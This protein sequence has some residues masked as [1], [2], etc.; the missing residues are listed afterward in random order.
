MSKRSKYTLIGAV[1]T[2]V[3]LGLIALVVNLTTYKPALAALPQSTTATSSPTASKV[4]LDG[5]WVAEDEKFTATI[6]NNKITILWKL[7]ETSKGLYWAGDFPS[8]IDEGAAIISTANRAKLDKS[9]VASQDDTKVF[10]HEDDHLSF[11]FGAM[12]V[13][14]TVVLSKK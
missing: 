13:T 14:K 10:T 12:G 6:K 8:T 2:V 4:V 7:D 1:A 9:L 3:A 11:E 5:V